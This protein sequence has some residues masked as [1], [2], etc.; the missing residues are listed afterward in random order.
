VAES[1]VRGPGDIRALRECG[2]DG[3]LIG[4]SL[5]RAA[6]KKAYLEKLLG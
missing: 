1:G 2:V 5:M 3:V 6:D 4:E